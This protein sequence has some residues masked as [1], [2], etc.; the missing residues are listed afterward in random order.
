MA[1]DDV[2]SDF[3]TSVSPEARL[4]IQ[5]ASGDEWLVTHFFLLG[6]TSAIRLNAHD[7]TRNF[8]IGCWGG[9]TAVESSELREIGLHE[10]RFFMTNSEYLRILNESDAATL[11][12]GYSAI[13]TKE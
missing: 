9:K 12:F 8:I 11:I 3:E 13:K 1:I 6:G 4:S 7:N 10:Y 5:P 2:I